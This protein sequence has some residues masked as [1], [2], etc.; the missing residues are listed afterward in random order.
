MA[1]FKVKVNAIQN[2]TEVISYLWWLLLFPLH[3]IIYKI[4]PVCVFGSQQC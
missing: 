4:V 3:Y 1:Q 2:S